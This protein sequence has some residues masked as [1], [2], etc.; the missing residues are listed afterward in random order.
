MSQQKNIKNKKTKAV[1]KR[2]I[3]AKEQFGEDS[4]VSVQNL[5]KLSKLYT[6]K[7]G[8]DIN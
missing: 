1:K 8:T 4:L 2:I 7:S 5:G 3:K 6:V